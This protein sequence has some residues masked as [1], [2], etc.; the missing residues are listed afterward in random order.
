MHTSS[1]Q[2][3]YQSNKTRQKIILKLF[4][5]LEVNRSEKENPSFKNLEIKD[6][7]STVLKGFFLQ[8]LKTCD[9]NKTVH[10]ER[11]PGYF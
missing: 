5:Y 1:K 2:I 7:S 10:F 3:K 11:L 4:E 9:T 8:I 6:L